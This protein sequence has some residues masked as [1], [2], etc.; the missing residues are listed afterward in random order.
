MCIKIWF[1]ELNTHLIGKN[2]LLYEIREILTTLYS[3]TLKEQLFKKMEINSKYDN[4]S[5]NYQKSKEFNLSTSFSLFKSF[6]LSYDNQMSDLCPSFG[7][8]NVYDNEDKQYKILEKGLSI[9][10]DTFSN[11][12]SV[13]YLNYS[14]IDT[15]IFYEN[16]NYKIL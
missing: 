1:A 5:M 7:S 4:K 6:N 9:I 13:Y 16:Y 15:N 8:I 2:T 3:E 12:Y 11:E 10:N 14:I